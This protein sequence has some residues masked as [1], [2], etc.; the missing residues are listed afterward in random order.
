MNFVGDVIFAGEHKSQ[1][2]SDF[3][4]FYM[5]LFLQF[6]QLLWSS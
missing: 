2:L 6:K 5:S 3:Q 4:L 1:G